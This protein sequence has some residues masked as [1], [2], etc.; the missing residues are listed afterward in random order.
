[1]WGGGGVV[2]KEHIEPIFRKVLRGKKLTPWK[3]GGR[4]G[5]HLLEA[6]VIFRFR[7][8]YLLK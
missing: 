5:I 8:F 3:D 4:G 7:F 2:E 6:L 1:M